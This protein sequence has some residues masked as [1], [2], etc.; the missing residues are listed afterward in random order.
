MDVIN[1]SGRHLY[2]RQGTAFNTRLILIDGRKETP[3]GFPP[4]IENPIPMNE[5]NSPTPVDNFDVLWQRINKS[6]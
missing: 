6:I 5:I 1:I 4:L 2:S 3:S